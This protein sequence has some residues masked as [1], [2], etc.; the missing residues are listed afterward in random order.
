MDLTGDEE[1]EGEIRDQEKKP[2][3]EKTVWLRLK[4]EQVRKK[5]KAVTKTDKKTG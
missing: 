2:E 5:K 3:K 4:R 1:E